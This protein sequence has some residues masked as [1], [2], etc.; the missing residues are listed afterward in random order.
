LHWEL[1]AFGNIAGKKIGGME[2]GIG[3]NKPD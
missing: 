2:N 1:E 3:T